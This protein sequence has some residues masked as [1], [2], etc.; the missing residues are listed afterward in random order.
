MS[1]ITRNLPRSVRSLIPYYARTFSTSLNCQ[2]TNNNDGI[3]KIEIKIEP[4]PRPNE[5]TDTKRARLLYQSRKRGILESDIILSRFAD[6]YL[7]TMTREELDEYDEL[8]DHSDWDIYYWAVKNTDAYV[9]PLPDRWKNSPILKKLQ[10]LSA[11][12]GKEVLRMPEL[13]L[14]DVKK[15]E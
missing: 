9:T 3:G 12:K 11:N 8:L 5:L 2:T 4:L 13:Q 14:K 10:N 6:K 15:D 1:L 7:S